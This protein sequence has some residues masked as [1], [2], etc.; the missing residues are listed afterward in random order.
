MKIAK[1][2]LWLTTH[3]AAEF[4]GITSGRVRQILQEQNKSAN[5]IGMKIGRDWL[6]SASDVERIRVL[7]G[8]RQSKNS[9]N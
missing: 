8:K 5:K 1:P 3:D 6:L 2:Q 4:L 9:E 7:P